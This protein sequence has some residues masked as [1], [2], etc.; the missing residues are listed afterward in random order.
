MRKFFYTTQT[1][2]EYNNFSELFNSYDDC[3]EAV[4]DN[5]MLYSETYKIYSFDT[6]E[7][8]EDE[9]TLDD[10][11]LEDIVSEDNF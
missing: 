9:F 1:N 2:D 5:F 3:L 7:V 6:D 11:D 10:C 8:S 4:E